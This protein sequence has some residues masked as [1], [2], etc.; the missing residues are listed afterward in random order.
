[1]QA[2]SAVPASRFKEIVQATLKADCRTITVVIAAQ[3]DSGGPNARAASKEAAAATAERAE[4]ITHS[5]V[6]A[7]LIHVQIALIPL[8]SGISRWVKSLGCRQTKNL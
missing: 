4:C 8:K 2:P 7:S 3:Y 5:D 1:M 6:S